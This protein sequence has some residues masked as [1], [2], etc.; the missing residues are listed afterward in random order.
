MPS[1]EN[2]KTLKRGLEKGSIRLTVNNDLSETAMIHT[3]LNCRLRT[4]D[5]SMFDLTNG[6]SVAPHMGDLQTPGIEYLAETLSMMFSGEM[7]V[8]TTV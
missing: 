2:K 8:E 6:F 4:K 1:T 5:V 7:Y 3:L